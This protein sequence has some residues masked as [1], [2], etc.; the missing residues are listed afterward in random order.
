MRK[1]FSALLFSLLVLG[2]PLLLGEA[3]AQ[4]TQVNDAVQT[5]ARLSYA[6]GEVSFWRSGA[7]DWSRAVINTPLA[8]GDELATGAR[9]TL[10][11][12]VGPRSFVRAWTDTQLGL[13]SQ[14]PDFLQFKMTA[15]HASFDLR[16]LDPGET[17]EVDTPNAAITIEHPGYYRVEIAGER[18]SIITRRAG[19]ATVTPASGESIAMLAS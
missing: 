13:S 4:E 9:G 17:V 15:G 18:T 14:E 3:A 6:D 2:T 7:P 12:Q 11:L 1:I 19:R 8:P 10:E 16:A 5:P